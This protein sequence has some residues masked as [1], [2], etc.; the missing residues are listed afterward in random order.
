MVRNYD[1]LEETEHNLGMKTSAFWTS[2]LMVDPANI[3]RLAA[4]FA[5]MN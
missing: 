5:I 3:A 2:P 1:D 4:Q